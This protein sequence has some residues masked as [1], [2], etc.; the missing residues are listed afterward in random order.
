MLE[1]HPCTAGDACVNPDRHAFEVF[2]QYCPGCWDKWGIVSYICNLPCYDKN[3]VSLTILLPFFIL[4]HLLSINLISSS[5]HYP[6]YG[7]ARRG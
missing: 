7:T 3:W 6:I 5:F 2:A 4:I 1:K